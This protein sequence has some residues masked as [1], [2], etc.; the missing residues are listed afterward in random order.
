M[1]PAALA[2]ARAAAY[3]VDSDSRFPVEA[4]AEVKAHGL[5]GALVPRA[6]GGHGASLAR[7][8]AQCQALAGACSASGMILAMHNIQ[9]ACLVRHAGDSVWLNGVLRRVA[10]EQL[11][12]ASATSEVGVGGSLRTSRC[13]VERDGERF[14]L[15]KQATAISYGRH[16][17]AIMATARAHAEASEGDQVLLVVDKDGLGLDPRGVWDA[18]GMRGTV[19]EPFVLSGSGGVGQILATPF[20]AIAAQTMTPIS[21]ILWSAVWTGVAGDAVARARAFLRRNHEPGAETPSQGAYA[22]GEAIEILQM[23]ESRLRDA[24]AAFDASG[25]QTPSFA[26]AASY[27]GLKASVAEACLAAT[28]K[29]LTVCGFAGYARKGDFSVERHLRDLNS[30]PLMIANMRMRE[31][32]AWLLLTQAPLL[33][34]DPEA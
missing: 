7:V 3:D 11:L 12:L 1:P 14:T 21:H 13:A 9:V 27:N 8:A 32:A 22:L 2:A 19:T 25:G 24:I 33:G 5:L 6:L 30:A 15:V 10:A 23:A 16:A 29:A 18:M 34:L 28:Q 17:D 4:F 31:A 26:E 20:G